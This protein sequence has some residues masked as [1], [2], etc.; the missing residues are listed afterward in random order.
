MPKTAPNPPRKTSLDSFRDVGSFRAPSP[1]LVGLGGGNE[2]MKRITTLCALCLSLLA[3]ATTQAETLPYALGLFE[4][5]AESF[6]RG[7]SDYKRGNSGEVSRYQIM[8]DVW[9]RYSTSRDYHNPAVAWEVAEKI[10]IERVNGFKARTGRT[11]NATEVYL[12]WNK[13]G[14]FAT[15]RYSLNRVSR[16]YLAR[17]QRFANIYQAV[18]VGYREREQAGGRQVAM[19]TPANKSEG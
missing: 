3:A 17:A 18:Q 12:L 5:G 7:S 16:Y 11:P 13:P 6:Q 10:L 2:N 1:E 15:A 14:H 8:P 4:S 9:K 19:V